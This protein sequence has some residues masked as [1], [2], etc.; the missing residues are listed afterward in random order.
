MPKGKGNRA[1]EVRQNIKRRR[2]GYRGY[3]SPLRRDA[4]QFGGAVHWGRGFTGIG[5]PGE[6]GSMLPREQEILPA[7]LHHGG[8][9]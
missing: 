9:K 2:R 4:E 1:D 8:R 3:G 5:F 6:A 7:E